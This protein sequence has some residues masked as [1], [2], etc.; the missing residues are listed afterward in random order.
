M[1]VVY[2][3]L[4]AKFSSQDDHRQKLSIVIILVFII[5]CF[6]YKNTAWA[7]A[8][9]ATGVEIG[10][11]FA[12]IDHQ[13]REVTDQDLRGKYL[14]V[15]F[16]FTYCPDICPTTLSD[17]SSVVDALDQ[18]ADRI[19]PLFITVDPERDDPAT[20]ASYLSHF[21]PAIV[22]LTGSLEAI[23]A[24]S[25]AY[26]V[27]RKKNGQGDSYLID[28]S[29]VTYLMSPEGAY[30]LHFSHGTNPFDIAQAILDEMN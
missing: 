16:G 1:I 7:E 24:V 20:L 8:K 18:D 13:G 21:D 6:V 12:L 19:T 10:G 15:F 4:S 27:Y 9:R 23:D 11:P 17:M 29:A 28:H 26:H 3:N 22:G 14:L 25:A 5:C 30:L 2:S